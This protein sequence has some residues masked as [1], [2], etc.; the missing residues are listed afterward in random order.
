[1]VVI[2][3]KQYEV[4]EDSTTLKDEPDRE[5]SYF[6]PSSRCAALDPLIEEHHVL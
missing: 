2:L 4:D 6:F 1:M 5:H 3:I